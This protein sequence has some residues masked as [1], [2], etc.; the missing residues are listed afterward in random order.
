MYKYGRGY[1]NIINVSAEIEFINTFLRG[2]TDYDI[3]Q[4]QLEVLYGREISLSR[5]NDVL[6]FGV[7]TEIHE[8]ILTQIYMRNKLIIQRCLFIAKSVDNE[9]SE[10]EIEKKVDEYDCQIMDY[11]VE[12]VEWVIN[13][14]QKHSSNDE[15]FTQNG[16]YS[17]LGWFRNIDLYQ[18]IYFGYNDNADKVEAA[19]EKVFSYRKYNHNHNN[20]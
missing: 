18:E 6:S 9:I 7:C 17:C 13:D 11:T 15:M 1:D 5:C 16:H 14:A 8:C 3:A 19:K 4:H 20:S 2:S 10:E 12:A